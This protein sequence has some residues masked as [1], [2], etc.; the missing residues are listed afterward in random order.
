VFIARG[1]GKPGELGGRGAERQS[2]S[3]DFPLGRDATIAGQI[4]MATKARPIKKSC[5]QKNSILMRW[6]PW[7]RFIL[8]NHALTRK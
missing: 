5:I 6:Y 2:S 3:S 7:Q 8:R 4:T 1:I